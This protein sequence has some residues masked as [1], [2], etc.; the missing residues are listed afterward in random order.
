MGRTST[1]PAKDTRGLSLSLSPSRERRGEERVWTKEQAH[2][3]V[4]TVRTGRERHAATVERDEKDKRF[5]VPMAWIHH[6]RERKRHP[7][8]YGV[9]FPGDRTQER[10]LPFSFSF[11]DTPT[12][13]LPSPRIVGRGRTPARLQDLVDHVHRTSTVHHPRHAR[14]WR[15]KDVR[16]RNEHAVGRRRR[17]R[18]DPYTS[19]LHARLGSVVGGRRFEND[20]RTSHRASTRGR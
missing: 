6:D 10:S 16:K 4:A 15:T 17:N 7:T 13:R 5:H 11:P 1:P 2:R 3:C 14:A 18:C 20:E 9:S 12:H 19:L 8:W